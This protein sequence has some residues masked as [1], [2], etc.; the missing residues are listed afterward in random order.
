M[1]KKAISLLIVL[2]VTISFM[3]TTYSASVFNPYGEFDALK[4]FWAFVESWKTAS[5]GKHSYRYVL[6]GDDAIITDYL[7]KGDDRYV[8]YSYDENG[9]KK[10]TLEY[11][12]LYI[13]AYL[14]GHKVVGIGDGC[15]RFENFP[16]PDDDVGGVVG[17][18]VEEWGFSFSGSYYL[19]RVV[20]P[21]TVKYIEDY[22]F[23]DC[24]NL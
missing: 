9:E 22:A 5:D 19:K 16:W 15:Y 6:S 8:I 14:D 21:N 1:K 7:D 24:L 17:E 13:P 11:E 18:L 4:Q 12:T 10:D 3:S 20:I 23:S 2:L